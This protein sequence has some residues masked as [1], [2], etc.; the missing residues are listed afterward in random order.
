MVTP[1]RASVTAKSLPM[2][3]CINYDNH[4]IQHDANY[5]G[6]RLVWWGKEAH[7]VIGWC[8]NA[9]CQD[10]DDA[11]LRYS[12]V[13]DPSDQRPTSPPN[14][15]HETKLMTLHKHSP[16]NLEECTSKN[17]S[18]GKLGC[19]RKEERKLSVAT[20][21]HYLFYLALAAR[22]E[23]TLMHSISCQLCSLG[24]WRALCRIRQ[25]IID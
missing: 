16:T 6:N 9:M 5:K 24:K 18:C 22:F 25:E 10:N 14:W 17:R 8:L 13:I 4:K 7:I 23:A 15:T 2:F 12:F 19:Y 11:W 1:T 21:L 20:D 3:V